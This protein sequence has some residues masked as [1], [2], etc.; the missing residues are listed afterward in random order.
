M[1]WNN[2]NEMRDHVPDSIKS[3][4]ARRAATVAAVLLGCLALAPMAS[5]SVAAEQV[6]IGIARTMSDVGYYVADAMG[7]FRDEGI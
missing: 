3:R 7:Y 4:C 5:P 2:D 6:K 1:I